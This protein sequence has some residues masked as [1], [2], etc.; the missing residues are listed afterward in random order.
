MYVYIYIVG[1]TEFKGICQEEGLDGEKSVC[2]EKCWDIHSWR[3]CTS[4]ST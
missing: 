4:L 1:S 3:K 2:V